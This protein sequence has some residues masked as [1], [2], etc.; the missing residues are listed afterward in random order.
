[1]DRPLLLL[2]RQRSKLLLLLLLLV[3]VLLMILL[4]LK[5]PP[6]RPARPAHGCSSSFFL[7]SAGRGCRCSLACALA[8]P[9]LCRHR[10]LLWFWPSLLPYWHHLAAMGGVAAA[11][12]AAAA[13][14]GAAA[15]LASPCIARTKRPA[16]NSTL[17]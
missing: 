9:L 6:R 13:A 8:K 17:E 2:L 11:A 7:L 14:A 10:H 12:A 15:A 5:R 1:V 3:V 4:L 16:C